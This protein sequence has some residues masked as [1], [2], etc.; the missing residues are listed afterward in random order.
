MRQSVS[1]NYV[2]ALIILGAVA[3]QFYIR[4]EALAYHIPFDDIIVAADLNVAA[5]KFGRLEVITALIRCKYIAVCVLLDV[6]T[7]R[8][9]GVYHVSPG[10]VVI[11]RIIRIHG[12][13]LGFR[14]CA[15]IDG[16]AVVIA[17]TV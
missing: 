2:T 7:L 10:D 5:R 4:S 17:K 12:L 9:V 8:A 3:F 14:A 1:T 16:L 6:E 15:D 11:R 13:I